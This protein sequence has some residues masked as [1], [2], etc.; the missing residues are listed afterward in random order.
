MLDP[1]R[2]P[3]WGW[4][5]AVVV[6]LL[7]V[8]MT[9]LFTYRQH[10]LSE[11]RRLAKEIQAQGRGV[12][13]GDFVAR[14]P[15]VDRARQA[16]AWMLIGNGGGGWFGSP[17]VKTWGM[18]ARF[19]RAAEMPKRDAESERILS[20]SATDRE[21]WK[22][23]HREGPV[24]VSAFGWVAEDLPDPANAGI[25]KT[26]AIRL[27]NLLA[28]RALATALATEAFRAPDPLPSLAELD[29]LVSAQ[30]PSGALIDA[31]ILMA[32]AAIRDQAW[33]E[34]VTR[35]ANPAPWRA[36]RNDLLAAVAEGFAAERMLFQGG[37]Y[38]DVIAGRSLSPV[39]MGMSGGTWKETAG[40]WVS[41]RIAYFT[42]PTD[43]AF[44]LRCSVHSED[45]CRTGIDGGA[46]LM[47]RL[48]DPWFRAIHPTASIIIPNLTESAITAVQAETAARR[49]RITGRLVH[50]WLAT[51][52]L[53]ADETTADFPDCDLLAAQRHGPAI[54]Y[55]RLTP[56]R[57][58]LWTD[59][60]TPPTDLLPAGRIDAPKP[61]TLPWY[62]GGWCTELDLSALTP[63]K[64]P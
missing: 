2:W 11:L 16:R 12:T 25:M 63:P 8:V 52:S 15:T 35:G 31:M 7:G 17:P 44:G 14:A 60:A 32:T 20:R 9:A 50:H 40:I 41:G 48:T 58:R 62:N 43:N 47:A 59:P 57:F 10:G 18:D 27:P 21:S 6:L 5:V 33:L 64:A 51:G 55:E 38:Q 3:W 24:V 1:R 19:L 56:T 53:P 37:L 26:A 36:D 46:P 45:F 49:L 28:V 61:T 39:M 13:P 4:V 34:A 23:L 42:M 54:L 29:A 22:K 30:K